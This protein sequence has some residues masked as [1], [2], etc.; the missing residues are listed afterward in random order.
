MN[1]RNIVHISDLFTFEFDNTIRFYHKYN[2]LLN[3]KTIYFEISDINLL[4]P[5]VISRI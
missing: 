3:I 1:V 5:S 2:K 4:M